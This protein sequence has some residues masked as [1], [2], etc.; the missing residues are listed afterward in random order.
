MMEIEVKLRVVDVSEARRKLLAL[1]ARVVRE[2]ALEENVLFDFPGGGLAAKRQALRLRL[3]GRKAFLTFKGAPRKSRSFKVRE[4]F[5]T[6]VRNGKQMKMILA[7]LGFREAFAYR[8]HRT[9][10]R[11]TRLAVTLDET[12][13]GNFVELEGERHEITRFAR[14]LGYKRTDFITRDYIAMITEAAAGGPG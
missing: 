7:A 8:K 1:G 5:E 3:V 10:L 9:W 12:A 11:T 13:V 14:S 6:E 2:R 4:E